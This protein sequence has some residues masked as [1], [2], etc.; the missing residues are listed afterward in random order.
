MPQWIWLTC[1]LCL[2]ITLQ[3]QPPKLTAEEYVEMYKHIAISEMHRTGIPASIKLA[4]GILESGAGNSRLAKEANN[5]FGIKCHKE[6]NGPSIRED[7]DAPKECFRKY[8]NAME[9]WMDHSEFLM[10]RPRYEELFK[11]NHTDY[12]GW[13]RGL[14]AAGYATNPQYAPLLIGIIERMELHQYDHADPGEKPIMAGLKSENTDGQSTAQA[15]KT[16]NYR[17]GIFETNRI[18]TVFLQP[19]Q[20]LADVAREHGLREAQLIRW[21]DVDDANTLKVGM[22]VFLAPKRNK[23]QAKYHKVRE[24]ETMYGIS[25]TYGIKL[26]KLYAWNLME[27][28]TEP[29]TGER[30]YLRG[31]RNNP[32]KLRATG[33]KAT[34]PIKELAQNDVEAQESEVPKAE[35]LK[36]V[37]AAPANAAPAEKKQPD[38][39]VKSESPS[40][41]DE[42]RYTYRGKDASP[43]NNGFSP[44]AEKPADKLPATSARVHTVEQGETLYSL[45]RKYGTTID[46]LMQ[47]N[48]MDTTGIYIGQQLVVDIGE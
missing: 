15:T 34:A 46:R 7:D 13:A 31:K 47:L 41:A 6:W 32:P 48:Q 20:K 28:A 23:A 25:Q 9:S 2:T 22:R 17:K 14:K 27:P 29:A 19:G 11:L 24:G 30:L 21:N 4:Q 33:T 45:S 18:K 16:S 39:P 44:S 38:T 12:E 35:T 1:F 43:E 8:S 42:P 26:A 5:H 36:I 3:G 40:K 10:T 37:E